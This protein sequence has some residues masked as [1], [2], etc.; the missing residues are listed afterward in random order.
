MVN[1]QFSVDQA[2]MQSRYNNLAI[3]Y[4]TFDNP[5]N[6]YPRPNKVQETPNFGSTLRYMDGGFIKLRTV[7]LGYNFSASILKKLGLTNMRVYVTAQNPLAWSSYT[8]QD[9]EQPVA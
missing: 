8:I 4:W 5:S 7:T 3:D 9:P 6:A 2:T 1:S